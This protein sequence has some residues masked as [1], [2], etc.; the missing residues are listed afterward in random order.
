MERTYTIRVRLVGDHLPGFSLEDEE[1][2]D[3]KSPGT[4]EDL[5]S[6]GLASVLDQHNIEIESVDADEA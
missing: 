6:Q 2:R 3:P 5:L 1:R 4:I